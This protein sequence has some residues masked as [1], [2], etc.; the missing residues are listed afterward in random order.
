MLVSLEMPRIARLDLFQTYIH[1]INQ[2]FAHNSAK[3][4]PLVP[5]HSHGLAC[6]QTGQMLSRGIA[7]RLAFLGSVDALKADAVLSLAV[8]EDCDGVAIGDQPPPGFV[9]VKNFAFD[10]ERLKAL[11]EMRHDIVH[12]RGP[13]VELPHGDDDI[14]FLQKTATFLLSLVNQRY[15][16]K[17]DPTYMKN[18]VKQQS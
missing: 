3:A 1:T 10:R 6:D 18:I 5:F 4:I 2:N 17:I 12:S 16:V 14:L 8:I 7:K 9:G 11:D 15:E 13:V